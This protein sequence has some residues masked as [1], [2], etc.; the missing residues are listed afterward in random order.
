MKEKNLEN[1]CL[2]V[3]F[4][5]SRVLLIVACSFYAVFPLSFWNQGFAEA[6]DG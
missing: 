1:V 4:V 5:L 3:A 6:T 2:V